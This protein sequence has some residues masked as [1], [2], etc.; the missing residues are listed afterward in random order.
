MGRRQGWNGRPT[1]GQDF[2]SGTCTIQTEHR[3]VT[4]HQVLLY[5]IEVSDAMAEAT[6]VDLVS[7]ASA[8]ID[9]AGA[10]AITRS[11]GL[12][13]RAYIKNSG[14]RSYL[15]LKGNPAQRAVLKG[16]RYLTTNPKVAHIII[17]PR[18][19]ARGAARMTGIAVVAYAALRVVEALLRDGDVRLTALLGTVASD[20]TKFALA[21]TAGFLAGAV[22]GSFTTVAAGPLVAAV[23]IGVLT[24][25]VVDRIDRSF[26]LTDKLVRTLEKVV[27]KVEGPFEWLAREIA[28]FERGLID[29]AVARSMSLSR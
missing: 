4:V 19:L 23:F 2:R 22:V 18:S 25:F 20:V 14:G 8:G 10:V 26:G 21:A 27:D 5:V 16:T 13:G 1:V 17:S 24:S 3:T 7:A 9:S 29:R 6:G 15:I 12:T 11:L 28:R